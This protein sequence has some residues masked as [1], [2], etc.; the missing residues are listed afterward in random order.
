MIVT[1][2]DI[3][4][5]K[6]A[7][8]KYQL[9]DKEYNEAKSKV[10][11]AIA[12][13]MD[14]PVPVDAGGY[15]HERHK[16]NYGEMQ[17]AG[18]LYQVTK[19]EKYSRFV[20][21]MLLHYASLYPTL[22]IHPAAASDSPGKLFWQSLNET[23]WL[24]N[25]IQA[26]DCVYDAIPASDR[27]IIE[28]NVFRPMVKF[29]SVDQ[30]SVLNRIHNHGTW[31]SAA[32]GMAGFA[33]RDTDMVAMALYG[34]EKNKQGGFLNQLE[35]LFSP[36]GYFV[37][38]P[39]YI[40]YAIMP[41]FVFAQSI[42]NNRPDLKIFEYRDGI[43]KKAFYT[44]LQLTYTTGQFLPINDA[45]KEKTYRSPEVILALNIAY[46]K[47]DNDKSF[48]SIA[49]EQNSVTLNG[50]GVDVARDL[51]KNKEIIPFPYKSLEL[52]DGANGDGGGVGILR[53]GS[54]NDQ[55]LALMK[56][57][58]HGL[59][60]GHYDKLSFLFYDQNREQLQDYGAARF[61]NVEPKYGGRYL[62]ETKSFAMQTIA[63]NTVTVDE[64][65]HYQGKIGISENFHADRNYFSSKEK[66]FQFMSAKCT[67]AYSDV[68]LQRT[69][70]MIDDPSLQKPVIVDLFKVDGKKEHTYDL[71][72]YYIGQFIYTNIKSTAYTSQ[73]STLGSANGYQHLWKEAEAKVNGMMQFS[74]LSGQRYYSVSSAADSQ[75]TVFFARIGANDP[76]YNLRREP[77]VIVRKKS[78][79]ALFASVI[80]PHGLWNGTIEIS[81]NASS[82]VKN[83]A[84]VTSDSTGSIVAIEW[85][86]GKTW[87][88]MISNQE[89]SDTQQH[90]KTANGVTYSW[91]GNAAIQKN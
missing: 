34:T 59:S 22:G 30:K 57:T 69:V 32:V 14:V 85:K 55:M 62:P 65:S 50:G 66:D 87:T 84:V 38:G 43:L 29:F 91:I 2:K 36:D 8:G 45:L 72:F 13:P 78:S 60:H 48:L 90:T 19:Q 31:M 44:M 10:D 1:A 49:R 75:T 12:S 26:Y 3:A 52:S 9:F 4:S 25:T 77:A 46:K 35:L 80:E 21:E 11:A 47:F 81:R 56:Y 68:S 74:W 27:K 58:G 76:N 88:I 20:K 79:S 39:Y 7:V 18:I 23:V 16:Q 42:D 41:F 64:Q 5:I 86:S 70:L 37:E 54:N 73:Q 51:S 33:L 6:S 17:M 71:P 15:T 53:H 83:I 40:R 63:H 24:V 82:A 61:I 67:N 28:T 89:A